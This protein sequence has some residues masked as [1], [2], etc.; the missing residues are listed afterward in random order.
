MASPSGATDPEDFQVQRR[1]PRDEAME[2]MLAATVELLVERPPEKVTIRDV[3]E[4]SGHHH[5]FV[6]SWFGGKVPL[7]R[8]AFDRLSLETADGVS[9]DLSGSQLGE[10]SVGLAWLLNWLV[11]ADPGASEDSP[12]PLIDRVSRIYGGTT[13]ASSR[14][15]RGCS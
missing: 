1:T 5:R 7:F 4:A 13:S 9:E 10:R 15:W 14:T 3:A 2:H 6:Q 11:A 12:T 8:A